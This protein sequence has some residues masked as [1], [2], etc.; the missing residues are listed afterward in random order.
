MDDRVAELWLDLA[1]PLRAY[2]A[3]HGRRGTDP[4]DLLQEC[5]LRVVRGIDGVRDDE[6]LGARVQGIA[7]HL[8][9]DS[10]RDEP[11]RE[12]L[13]VEPASAS[14]AVEGRTTEDLD[15]LV[16]G[17]IRA[18]VELLPEP[19]GEALRLFELE[20][21]PQSEIAERL[22]VSGGA[23]KSRIHRGR[24]SVREDLIACCAF[25]FDGRGNVVD[26]KRR[27]EPGCH[28]C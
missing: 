28:D 20:R 14:P 12:A 1:A 10:L 18:R 27:R 17:W 6:R 3:R 23:V 24:A 4:E 5:F 21:L 15:G 13:V 19:Y 25:E 26:W 16:S 22:G 2:F 11:T 8:A 9:V 7:R